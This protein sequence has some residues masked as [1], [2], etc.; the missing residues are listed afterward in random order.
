[1]AVQ[2]FRFLRSGKVPLACS[3]ELL[4][5]ATSKKEEHPTLSRRWHNLKIVKLKSGRVV[6]AIEFDTSWASETPRYEADVCNDL[7]EAVNYARE[8]DPADKVN[9][10]PPHM[11]ERQERLIAELEAGYDAMCDEAESKLFKPEVVE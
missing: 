4:F 3:G 11:P 1:M 5:E 6:V 8:F 10:F 2:E 9:G 7:N